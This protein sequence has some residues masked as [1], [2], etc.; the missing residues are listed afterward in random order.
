[1]MMTISWTP[2]NHTSDCS[3]TTNSHLYFILHSIS[4]SSLN[5]IVHSILL[6]IFP[7]IFLQSPYLLVSNFSSRRWHKIWYWR[8]RRPPLSNA[9]YL[10][11]PLFITRVR[12]LSDVRARV[13]PNLRGA[14]RSQHLFYIS[15]F[16][17]VQQPH[18]SSYSLGNTGGRNRRKSHV[19]IYHFYGRV[20]SVRQFLKIIPSPWSFPVMGSW[21]G[22][23]G[24]VIIN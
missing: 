10:P 12:L 2:G 19:I 9:S 6:S 20:S 1:M 15:Q 5:I 16:L 8:D 13:S 22:L 18:T 3:V 11:V 17:M 24:T 7:T 23:P 21:A 14:G 4:S